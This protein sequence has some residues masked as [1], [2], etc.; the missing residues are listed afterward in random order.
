MAKRVF[1]ERLKDQRRHQRLAGLRIG[2]EVDDQ[3]ITIPHALKIEIGRQHVE[4]SPKRGFIV[5]RKIQRHAQQ[6][7]EPDD[8]R[9]SGGGIVI[10]EMRR[11]ESSRRIVEEN[12]Q[13]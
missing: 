10:E 7:A 6:P 5:S 9:V 3:P 8:H 4:L 2:V 11:G 12:R 13:G 1:G